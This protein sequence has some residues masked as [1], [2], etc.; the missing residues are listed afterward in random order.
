MPAAETLASD[1]L[2][3]DGT[4]A[5]PGVAAAVAAA[6]VVPGT[7]TEAPLPPSA[8]GR[9]D[10]ARDWGVG[11]ALT[12]RMR[13]TIG[14]GP[15]PPP[16][17]PP[18]ARRAAAS[19]AGGRTGAGSAPTALPVGDVRP[20]EAAETTGW[21]G[22]PAPPAATAPGASLGVDG[23]GTEGAGGNRE[24]W[25]WGGAAVAGSDA[26]ASG[27]GRTRATTGT[28]C[29]PKGVMGPQQTHEGGE[30]AAREAH[31]NKH[32]PEK[33]NG[34]GGG[35][36][37]TITQWG[38]REAEAGEGRKEYAASFKQNGETICGLDLH[39]CTRASLLL[40]APVF[41]NAVHVRYAG[42]DGAGGPART[43]G[44]P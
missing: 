28:S 26:N 18:L 25:A 41:G 14:R 6:A 27:T 2:W 24:G 19:P 44:R 40:Q 39:H 8:P 12:D 23:G 15:S 22:G 30:A 29:N 1:A 10:C 43:P 36:V 20:L 32:W 7:G 4:A 33:Q 38:A 35:S 3:M 9:R 17:A 13:V 42:A 21:R 11:S 37:P 34:M 16:K 5:A 31:R